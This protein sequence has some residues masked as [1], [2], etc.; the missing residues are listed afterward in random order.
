[1]GHRTR[2]VERAEH[3]IREM[4]EFATYEALMRRLKP[5]ELS[6]CKFTFHQIKRKLFP[7]ARK[8]TVTAGRVAEILKIAGPECTYQRVL[9]GLKQFD[10]DCS[11]HVFRRYKRLVF[12]DGVG[13]P[14]TDGGCLIGAPVAPP[15]P[16][17]TPTETNGH[18]PVVE[19]DPAFKGDFL[20]RLARFAS[21]VEDVGGIGAARRM[22][23]ALQNLQGV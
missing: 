1:M 23:D 12:P 4:G 8:L 17:P 3:F 14:A 22:L 5:E 7:G 6:V 11:E 18:M 10:D 9:E 15:A 2:A 19:A 21:I 20:I 13:R 16:D